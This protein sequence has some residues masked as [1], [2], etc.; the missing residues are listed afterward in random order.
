VIFYE[1]IFLHNLPI[2]YILL[3]KYWIIVFTFITISFGWYYYIFQKFQLNDLSNAISIYNNILTLLFACIVW[4]FAFLQLQEGKISR[5]E[6]EWEVYP[7][8]YSYVR[9]LQT[10]S[11]LY[12]IVPNNHTYITNSLELQL[13]LEKND[14]FDKLFQ[15]LMKNCLEKEEKLIYY[16][17]LVLKHFFTLHM[18]EYESSIKQYLEFAKK[19]NIT[20][21]NW[22][23]NHVMNSPLFLWMKQDRKD[24]FM[25]FVNYARN[26]HLGN[27]KDE[28]EKEYLT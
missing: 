20:S 18:G 23:F 16:Y 8:N 28:F 2:L 15:E 19:E 9:A 5:L 3:K 4:Y 24:E 14:E 13:I 26:Q 27:S 1:V 22:N 12:S 17:L 11:E 25:K 7:Q 6:N 10:Y 21:I